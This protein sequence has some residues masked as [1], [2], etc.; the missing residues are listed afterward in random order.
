[1]I[2]PN[3]PRALPVCLHILIHINDFPLS[4]GEYDSH[5]QGD[6]TMIKDVLVHIPTERFLRPVIDASVSLAA[7]Y[8]AHLDAMAIGYISNSA[9]YV[10]EGGAAVAA[11]FEFERERAVER[12]EAAL[13]VFET[14]A[15]N[16]GISY[17][18]KAI[19]S[20]PAEAAA[21]IGATARLYDLTVVLQPEGGHDTFDNVIPQEILFQAG[22]PVLFIPHI[23][24]GTLPGKRIGICWD[25]SRLAARAVRDAAPFLQ[26]ADEIVTITLNEAKSIP[27]EAS[28][29]SLAKHLARVALP[30]RIIALTANRSDIQPT[31]LSLAADENLDMLVMGGYGHSR[32]HETVLGGVTRA[33][34]QTMT[35]PT[36]MSH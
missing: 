22:G 14:A 34:L 10:V 12:A 3:K 11:V 33:M 2:A 1:V 17:T 9:P 8:A 13:G 16:A 32:L 5:L 30:T 24:H 20:I 19:A 28:A 35:V 4:C 21:A 29:D 26:H 25:G 7:T 27:A 6:A 23:F 18:Y 36:L 15:R 31:I